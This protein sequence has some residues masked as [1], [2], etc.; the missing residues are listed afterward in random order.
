[1]I[2]CRWFYRK[3]DTRLHPSQKKALR[4]N[5]LLISDSKD[6]NPIYSIIAKIQVS[7]IKTAGSKFEGPF[8]CR[9][10]YDSVRKKTYT[11]DMFVKQSE[12]RRASKKPRQK[13]ADGGSGRT[14]TAAGVTSAA[15]DESATGKKSRVRPKKL[16]AKKA[17]SKKR[18]SAL[19]PSSAHPPSSHLPSATSSDRVDHVRVSDVL[20]DADN[21][22]TAAAAD[23]DDDAASIVSSA[24]NA[25]FASS[26]SASSSSSEENHGEPRVGNDFQVTNIPDY[27]GP[28]LKRKEAANTDK[29]T[30]CE[31]IVQKTIGLLSKGCV[32]RL[33]AKPGH[34]PSEWATVVGVSRIEP[35]SST[36]STTVASAETKRET[37]EEETRKKEEV[38]DNDDDDD[39]EDFVIQEFD[40]I[41]ATTPPSSSSSSSPSGASGVVITSTASSSSAPDTTTT[42][43]LTLDEIP[44]HETRITFDVRRI[45]NGSRVEGVPIEA[46]TGLEVPKDWV[47]EALHNARSL[48]LSP[49]TVQELARRTI[50]CK[51]KLDDM[52]QLA[53]LLDV[54]GERFRRIAEHSIG[55]RDPKDV[56]SVVAQYYWQH[57]K[58]WTSVYRAHLS[59]QLN[60]PRRM[61]ACKFCTF[62]N[63]T[64]CE[65]CKMCNEPRIGYGHR[66]ARRK[67]EETYNAL[68]ITSSKRRRQRR[69]GAAA[70]E[71]EAGRVQDG[72]SGGNIKRKRGK[73]C[74]SKKKTSVGDDDD[75]FKSKRKRGRH[76]GTKTKTKTYED[77]F[78][79]ISSV[80]MFVHELRVRYREKPHIFATV[81][82]ILAEFR[83][84]HTS[85]SAAGVCTRIYALLRDSKKLREEFVRLVSKG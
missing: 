41:P 59:S 38:V 68:A 12:R 35:P 71:T 73:P 80:D 45:V 75:D 23:D 20:G 6:I 37:N 47:M 29:D 3:Q 54:H 22:D 60:R 85:L 79:E 51:W 14:T 43:T 19:P 83:S 48:T 34:P 5:E 31:D 82:K 11:T 32:V 7:G 27:I 74:G 78:D 67:Q 66:A 16:T 76:R 62:V 18:E 58:G 57:R 72:T 26:S 21:D 77:H 17:T 33:R 53:N 40:E 10:K 46:L 49:A 28:S 1:M 56:R 50:R 69:K 39:D 81:T 36:I 30:V 52:M 13:S 25:S 55:D 4:A 24:S 8:F 70:G 9:L 2:E 65:R 84:G 42:T 44:T 63:A 64:M 15:R 61:W